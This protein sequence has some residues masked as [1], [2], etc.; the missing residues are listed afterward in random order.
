MKTEGRPGKHILYKTCASVGLQN[1]I[2]KIFLPY[3]DE[4]QLKANRFSCS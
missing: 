1:I 3:S 4:R 2:T